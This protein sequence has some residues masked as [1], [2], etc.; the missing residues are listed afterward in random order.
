MKPDLSVFFSSP[1][2][3]FSQHFQKISSSMNF[4]PVKSLD[5]PLPCLEEALFVQKQ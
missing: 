1:Q 4:G 5:F 2:L 3:F